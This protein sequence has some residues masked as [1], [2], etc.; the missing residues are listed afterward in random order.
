MALPFAPGS[1]DVVLCGDLIEHLRDPDA[2]LARL[3]PPPPSRRG[4]SCSRPRTSPT[5]RCG[6]RSLAGRWRY[7]ERGILDRTHMHLFTR[8]TL[9]ETRRS[10]PA[11]A[12]SSSITPRLCPGS[13]RL[14]S[15][16]SPTRSPAFGPPSSRTSSSSSPTHDL[17][18]HPRQG[19]RRRPRPLPRRDRPPDRRRSGRGRRR[20]SGS[21]DGSPE[22]ARG[23]APACSRSRRRTSATAAP[24]CSARER[25]RRDP[26]LHVAGRVADDEDWLARLVAPLSGDASP[27]S[28]AASSRTS[29]Q[30]VRAVLPRLP[31]RTEAERQR[32]VDPSRL[33]LPLHALLERELGDPARRARAVSARRRRD[34]ERGP[35][36]VSPR[37]S[38]RSRDRV[39]AARRRPPLARVHARH[40]VPSLLRLGRLRRSRV[41]E[42]DAS[43][44]ALRRAGARY[45]ARSRV[46]LA[47]APTAAGCR[48]RRLRVGKFAGLQLGSPPRAHPR[49]ARRAAGRA[50]G[51]GRG[52][53]ARGRRPRPPA[54]ERHRARRKPDDDDGVVRDDR[55][56][57]Q[58]LGGLVP[59]PGSATA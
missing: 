31:L 37:P 25:A 33:T 2:T 40:G 11:T 18:R 30:T 39:R 1:F 27:A 47:H 53:R 22:R 38:R 58:P 20:R 36:V 51:A 14:P 21:R 24:A 57:A 59:A 29:M 46:A 16:G 45:A 13:A 42:G 28:T 26:G 6:C 5:G 19:R 48:T 12:S 49:P 32:L 56:P 50:P 34:D 52:A 55:R 8:A 44:A 35:G 10:V 23:S 15:S 9:V 3:R 41:R 4:G 43:R 54:R 17:G 7:T